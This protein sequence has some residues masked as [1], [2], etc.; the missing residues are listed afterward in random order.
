MRERDGAMQGDWTK[1]DDFVH[2]NAPGV[3]R[4]REAKT[5]EDRRV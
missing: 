4:A 5:E 1:T 3:E 2:A